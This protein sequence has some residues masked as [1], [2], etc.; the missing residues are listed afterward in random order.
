MTRR[1]SPRPD[2][3]RPMAIRYDE[4]TMHL[5]GDTDAGYVGDR[6]YVS[7]DRIHLLEFSLPPRTRF[8]HSDSNRTVFA[9]DEVLHVVEG[10]MLLVNPETGEA[11]VARTGESIFFRRDTWHHAINRSPDRPLRI[12]EFF[13]PPPATGA[14]STYARTRPYLDRW[15]YA[16]D[17]WL[18]RWPMARA[19]RER[20]RCFHLAGKRDLLWRVDDPADDLLVG[21]IAGTEHLTVG[22]GVLLPGQKSLVRSHGGDLVM[23][24]L[25]GAIGV[26][27]PDQTEPPS[28]FELGVGDAFYSPTGCRYQYLAHGAEPAEILFGVAPTY[29]PGPV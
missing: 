20:G 3:D 1:S 17:R 13:A 29:L 27:L 19:E 12:M 18:G 4:A 11:E 6:I 14:S 21:L 15:R 8:T 24:V 16:D 22:R 23:V 26:F 28:W 25:A 5:W 10:E 9:A 7:S 2:F